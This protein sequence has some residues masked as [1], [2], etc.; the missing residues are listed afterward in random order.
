MNEEEIKQYLKE[1]LK[2]EHTLVGGRGVPWHEGFVLKIDDEII[3]MAEGGVGG[4]Y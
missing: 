3:S 1:H 2:L 4:Y